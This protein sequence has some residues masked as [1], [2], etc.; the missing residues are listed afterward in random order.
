M[1]LASFRLKQCLRALATLPSG[2]AVLE[3][4]CGAGQ[5]I[6][7]VKRARP[8]LVCHGADISQQAI[9]LSQ[10]MNDGVIYVVNSDTL[11]YAN[12]SMDAVLIFDVF[13]HVTDPGAIVREVYRV[14]KPDGLLYAYV[15]CEG[16]GT[17]LWHLCR[18]LG[19][20]GE[21]TRNY[22][23]HINYFSRASLA[24]VYRAAGFTK[25][26]FRYSE[27]IIG[28]LLNF[29]AFNLMDRAAR[30]KGVAQINGEEYFAE[31]DQSV[32]HRGLFQ[33]LK[34]VVNSLV[35]FESWLFNRVPSPNVHGI[36]RK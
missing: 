30:K 24:A 26:S 33:A 13:E 17:S 3:F 20:K 14:L 7:S 15:P 25:I 4:G 35:Y 27:H 28:Q 16:D 11:P 21:L 29:L 31:L 19:W 34:G 32:S 8:D 10:K 6:R 2:S 1:S 5:F 23:G 18:A 22:A 12:G 9:E 36:A